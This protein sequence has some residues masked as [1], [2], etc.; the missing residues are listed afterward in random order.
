VLKDV[1]ALWDNGTLELTHL[2]AGAAVLP[3]QI[4][5]ERKRGPEGQVARH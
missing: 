2:P 4:L 3:F 5:C 1:N